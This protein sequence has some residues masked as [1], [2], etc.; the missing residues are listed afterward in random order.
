M[1]TFGGVS[2]APGDECR[3]VV[4]QDQDGRLPRDAGDLAVDELVSDEIADHK[5]APAGRMVGQRQQPLLAFGFA[6][7]RVDGTGE[8]HGE[9]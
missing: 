4:L 3:R 2:R 5:D 1:S 6:R 9:F 7:Q 8:Q